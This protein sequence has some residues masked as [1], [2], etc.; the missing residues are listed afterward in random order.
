MPVH[1]GLA[2]VDAP[3]GDVFYNPTQVFNRDISLLATATFLR[4]QAEKRENNNTPFRILE[5]LSASGL[6]S[7]RMMKELPPEIPVHLIV[8]DISEAAVEV[9]KKNIENN[10]DETTKLHIAEASHRD[11]LELMY[12]TY[13]RPENKHFDVIDLDPY[14]SPS[15]FIPAALVAVKNGGMISVTATD[16]RVLCGSQQDVCFGR[17]G[18]LSIHNDLDKEAALRLII[19]TVVEQAC[20]I[21]LVATPLMSFFHAHYMRVFFRIS[22]ASKEIN[23]AGASIGVVHTCSQCCSFFPCSFLSETSKKSRKGNE[24]IVINGN[25]GPNI[26]KQQYSTSEECEETIRKRRDMIRCPLCGGKLSIGGPMWLGSLHDTEFI[27]EMKKMLPEL[28][29]SAS[30]K[31]EGIITALLDYQ[32]QESLDGDLP[33]FYTLS[34]LARISRSSS[35]SLKKM[36]SLIHSL[37]YRVSVSH[38]VSGAIRTDAP[39]EC[40]ASVVRL[41]AK[42]SHIITKDVG[43]PIEKGSYCYNYMEGQSAH[44]TE[45]ELKKLLEEYK[46]LEKDSSLDS[47]GKDLVN[48]ITKGEGPLVSLYCELPEGFTKDRIMTNKTRLFLPNPEPNWG[49]KRAAPIKKKE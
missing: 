9:I 15:L 3:D 35:P 44:I 29:K 49:P 14:G 11:A 41:W 38:T 47:I 6:R 4:L 26:P 23:R 13:G 22:S 25:S 8:N 36:A 21:R 37:G 5:A 48:S 32:E 17:Y 12:H 1:E 10:K 33:F 2:H 42:I 31:N 34:Q 16:T 20:H 30:L 43:K 24:T 7:I 46:I 18:G 28:K 39:P 19:K 27:R 45:D 40:V